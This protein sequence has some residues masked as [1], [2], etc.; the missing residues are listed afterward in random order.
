MNALYKYAAKLALIGLLIG[1]II[2]GL[3]LL[4]GPGIIEHFTK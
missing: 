2:A 1:I 4:F 3:F